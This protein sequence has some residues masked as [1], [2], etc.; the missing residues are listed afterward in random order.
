[1][2]DLRSAWTAAKQYAA[3]SHDRAMLLGYNVGYSVGAPLGQDAD[4]V[5]F[6]VRR[7]DQPSDTARAFATTA[8]INAYLDDLATLP[9]YCLEL[10]CNPRIKVTSDTDGTATWITDTETG[11]RFGIRTADLESATQLCVHAKVPPTIGNW[12]R[13]N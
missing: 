6:W 9:R 12:H 10:Q 3:A 8:E 7:V 4:E 5:S 1:M 11:E 13:E 2:P